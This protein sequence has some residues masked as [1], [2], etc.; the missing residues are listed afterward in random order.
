MDPQLFARLLSDPKMAV[1]LADLK[2][3]PEKDVREAAN[4]FQQMLD[5]ASGRESE[6]KPA[7]ARPMGRPLRPLRLLGFQS[8]L[9]RLADPLDPEYAG[10]CFWPPISSVPDFG[11]RA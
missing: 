8:T 1:L 4:G 10:N 2:K 6:P 11:R 5:R 7:A 3:H 9:G